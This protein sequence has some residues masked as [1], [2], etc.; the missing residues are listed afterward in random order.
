M[1]SQAEESR[2][3]KKEFHQTTYEPF[4]RPLY[5]PGWDIDPTMTCDNIL[6][7][8]PPGGQFFLCCDITQF[9]QRTQ[10]RGEGDGKVELLLPLQ[11]HPI[12]RFAAG[13]FHEWLLTLQQ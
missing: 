13:T 2:K 4:F 6:H 12:N 3:G 9:G 10:Q 11:V 8:L 1:Q 7:K 5:S